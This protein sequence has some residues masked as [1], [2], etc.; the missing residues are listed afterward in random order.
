MTY[1]SIIL[2]AKVSPIIQNIFTYYSN[3]FTDYSSNLHLILT[4]NSIIVYVLSI[5]KGIRKISESHMIIIIIMYLHLETTHHFVPVAVETLG[6]IG[7]E[8]IAFLKE[9]GRRI[10][11]T[12]FEPLSY[13]Y[14]L[15]RVAV[16]I[17]RGNAAAVLGT[18]SRG[19]GL[20]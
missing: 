2:F 18:I 15:Q 17:Q 1:Y 5:R 19:V 3:N 14:L 12:C 9:L 4:F 7:E 11:A 20:G 10:A 8:G 16:A 6:P 13:Q